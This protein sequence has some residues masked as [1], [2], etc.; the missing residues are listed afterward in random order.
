MNDAPGMASFDRRARSG[1]RLSVVFLGGSLTWGAQA[2]D[3]Q[4]TSYRARISRMLEDEYPAA[5][6]KFWDAAIGGTGSPLAAFRLDRDVISR[7]PDLVFLDFTVNDGPQNDADKSAAYES[8]VRRLIQRKTPVLVAMFGAERDILESSPRPIEASHRAIAAAYQLPLADAAAL[9]RQ[10]VQSGRVDTRALWPIPNDRTHP[11][12]EG[13]RLYAQSVWEA[14]Q[15]AV[16]QSMPCRM[17]SAMLNAD[18]YMTVNRWR[19]SSSDKLPSGWAADTPSRT[20]V[21]YDF[22]MSR[23]LDDVSVASSGDGGQPHPLL[24][25][26]RGRN[27]FLFGE[28]GP[29]SGRFQIRI[30][31]GAPSIHDLAALGRHGNTRYFGTLA[32]GLDG[33]EHTLELTP[34]LEPGQ[35][36]RLESICL[37]GASAT[38]NHLARE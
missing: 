23:W 6:F 24:L 38:I 18:T 26:I 35:C 12:D 10:E 17:P 29:D 31:G 11:G 21:S 28:A 4:L 22:M 1:E 37:A 2:T 33:G 13:Y 3:P 32:S 34:I 19:I 15:A 14:Y 16:H 9:I 7:S 30:D 27:V 25:T 5:H 8:L 20:A 36:L